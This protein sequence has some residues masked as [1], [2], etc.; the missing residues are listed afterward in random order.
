MHCL[1]CR[2]IFLSQLSPHVRTEQTTRTSGCAALPYT[3]APALQQLDHFKQLRA[4]TS[5]PLAMGVSL[6]SLRKAVQGV[7][8]FP[9]ADRVNV[10]GQELF[11]NVNE[12]LPLIRDRLIDFIRV[13]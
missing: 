5:V 3:F 12:Y 4:Q 11:V 9:D 8:L 10:W 13:Q 2:S 6:I 7:L 1:H